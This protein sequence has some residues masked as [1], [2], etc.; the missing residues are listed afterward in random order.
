MF[1]PQT[2]PPAKKET[3]L[4]PVFTIS[5]ED[6]Q[7]VGDPIRAFTMY[8]VH[9]KARS[10]RVRLCVD[11]TIA[12]SRRLLRRFPSPHFL[13]FAAIQTSFGYMKPFQSITLAWLFLLF[14]RRVLSDASMTSSYDNGGAHWRIA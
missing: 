10:V 4:Q 1:P 11:V 2:A 14:P 6:P 12:F 7:K 9:T 8:T 3:G 5:V 13:F